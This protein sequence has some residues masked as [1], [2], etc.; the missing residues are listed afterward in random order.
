MFRQSKLLV[1][2]LSIG[3]VVLLFAAAMFVASYDLP[4]PAL[5]PVGPAAFPRAAAVI[6][7]GL[8]MAVMGSAIRRNIAPRESVERRQRADLLLA[9]I[10]ATVVYFCAMQFEI[11][12]FR[13]A[14][15]IYAFLLTV[16]LSDFKTA[17]ILPATIWAVSLGFGVHWVFTRFLFVDLP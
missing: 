14:T 5:E 3:V 2:E 11:L 4:P 17:A 1:A 8:A 7:F 13:W 12:G 15:V 9:S 16:I 10:A 6:L